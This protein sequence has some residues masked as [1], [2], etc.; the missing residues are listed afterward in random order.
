M[1]EPIP[2]GL[3]ASDPSAAQRKQVEAMAGFGIPE[4]AIA[5]VMRVDAPTLRRHFTDELAEGQI[6]ANSKVAENLYRKATGEGREA[7]TAAIFWLKTRAGW[8]ETVAHE[9]SGPD[10]GA[11]E[12]A[13]TSPRDMAKAILMI[14]TRA[15]AEAE[16]VE[17]EQ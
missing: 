9:V 17:A 10:G 8:K 4:A 11:I 5:R 7:V 16:S 6:K 15:G 3:E 1:S 12:T 14:L 13:E 2:A